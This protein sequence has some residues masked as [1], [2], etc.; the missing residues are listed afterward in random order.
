M[1]T[2]TWNLFA[3]MSLSKARSKGKEEEGK[4][5]VTF[6]RGLVPLAGKFS[7]PGMVEKQSANTAR[8]PT[9]SC[10]NP[11]SKLTLNIDSQFQTAVLP[12]GKKN[13]FPSLKIA[14]IHICV[15][16]EE[17]AIREVYT[18]KSQWFILQ[19]AGNFKESLPSSVAAAPT[20]KGQLK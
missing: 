16:Q 7:L 4:V 11:D 10:R 20:Q 14:W 3:N 12:K 1:Y 13:S 2:F 5:Q 6:T 8:P 9:D 15:S 18:A 19:M 17:R